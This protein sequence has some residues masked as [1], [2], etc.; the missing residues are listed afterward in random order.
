MRHSSRISRRKFL[1]SSGAAGTAAIGLSGKATGYTRAEMQARAAD[2]K[3]AGISKWDVDT[4]AL[5]VDLD[6]LE[7]NLA[8]MRTKL[9]GTNVA[10]RPHG[11]THKCPSIAKLQ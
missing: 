3:L 7:Q 9:A 10:S 1:V 4:P 6:R 11:K 8:A 5:C 2:G